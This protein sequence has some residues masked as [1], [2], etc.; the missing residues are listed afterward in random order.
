MPTLTFRQLMEM[1]QRSPEHFY[2]DQSS[3][4]D[5]LRPPFP[6]P[7]KAVV[8]LSRDISNNLMTVIE[9]LDPAYRAKLQG[10]PRDTFI[11]GTNRTGFN[12]PYTPAMSMAR[13]AS[14]MAL[15]A[16]RGWTFATPLTGLEGGGRWNQ[17]ISLSSDVETTL[18]ELIHIINSD[19]YLSELTDEALSYLGTGNFEDYTKIYGKY[20]GSLTEAEAKIVNDR[21]IKKYQDEFGKKPESTTLNSLMRFLRLK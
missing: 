7:A 8:P 18:H 3:L 12:P 21:L 1:F 4:S 5:Q 17:G 15:N 10:M 6:S 14:D 13:T 16:A 2:S 20:Q 11:M 19:A 9:N